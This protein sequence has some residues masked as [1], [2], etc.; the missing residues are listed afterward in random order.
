MHHRTLSSVGLEPRNKVREGRARPAAIARLQHQ[1]LAGCHVVAL[2]IKPCGWPCPGGESPRSDRT[3]VN[4]AP[5]EFRGR[6]QCPGERMVGLG[7]VR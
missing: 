6:F 3:P 5:S 1:E 2:A 7:I 4:E